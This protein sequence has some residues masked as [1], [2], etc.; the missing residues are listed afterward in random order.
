MGKFVQWRVEPDPRQAKSRAHRL[1]WHFEEEQIAAEALLD[2]CYIIR[3]D[4][5]R[6]ALETREVVQAYKDLGHVERAFRNLKTVQL[7]IRPVYLKKDDRIRA[8]VFLCVLAY[9]VQW[10][11]RQRLEPLFAGDGQGQHR[12]WTFGNVLEHLRQLT[13]NTVAL[14][15][16]QFEQTTDLDA[17][18]Q[19]IVELLGISL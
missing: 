4:A 17:D 18:H 1:L 5:P 13:S 15:A 19:R 3:T 11:L 14:G 16:V 12:R 9:Y 6:E 10:H 7:E 8:H 2:G